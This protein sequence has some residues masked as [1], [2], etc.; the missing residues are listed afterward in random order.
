MVTAA[1]KGRQQLAA[2]FDMDGV[3]VDSYQAHWQSWLQMLQE[4]GVILTESVFASLFGRTS[5]DIIRTLM[6]PELPEQRITALDK[7]KEALYRNILRHHF[8]AMDGAVELIDALAAAGYLLGIGSS[9]PTENVTVVL[10]GLERAH[11]FAAVV[12]GQDVDLGKPNPQVFLLAAARLGV[13]PS[14]CAV[15]EDAPAGIEAAL[16]GGMAT[17]ALTG[18]APREKLLHAHLIVDS[19]H[20]LDVTR[21][22]DLILKRP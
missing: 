2:I 12:T 10:E 9:G 15:I 3:L 6:G 18:T 20:Q 4:N 1:E 19:L 17:I 7:R 16:A 11:C 8:P 21:I 14:R 5:R 22:A 13:L